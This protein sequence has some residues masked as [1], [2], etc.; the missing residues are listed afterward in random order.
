VG[1]LSGAGPDAVTFLA[2][3][4]YRKQLADTHAAAVVLEEKHRK[5]CP[6]ASLVHPQPYL[7]YARIA[8][9]LNPPP[10][11]VP[12]IAASAAVAASARVAATAEVGAHAVIGDGCVIGDG[13]TIGPGCVLG[14][15]V[16][17]GAGSRLVARVTVLNG[18]RI[19]ARCIVQPGAVIGADG[20]GFAP[21]AGTWF[22]IPQLGSV[23]IGDDVEIGANT[24][25]DRGTIDDTV[26]E[27]GVKLDNFVQIAHNVRV[28]AHTIMAAMSGAAG[29]T[30]IGKRCMLGG[31]AVMINQISVC[32]DVIILFRGAVTKSID[33]PGVYSG[34]LPVDEAALWRRNAARFKKLDSL[35]ER[36]SAAERALGITG[37]TKEEPTD[38]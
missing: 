3:P 35:A 36:L 17:V 31:G 26:I 15:D 28:G 27:D 11:A 9:Y 2:N 18:V 38:D 16:T 33:K 6:V 4:A 25:V 22:K 7:T 12:G 14:A 5:A 8:T 21:N 23:V 13:A 19:G 20:F 1:T 30:R 24:C 10:A 34:T 29:S 37:K 32:D